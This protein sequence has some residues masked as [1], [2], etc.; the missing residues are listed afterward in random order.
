MGSCETCKH[1]NTYTCDDCEHH[2]TDLMDLYEPVEPEK[3]AEIEEKERQEKVTSAITEWLELDLTEEFKN[4]FYI[5]KKFSASNH[6]RGLFMAV[7]VDKDAKNLI[8]SDTIALIKMPCFTIPKELAGKVIFK[9]EGNRIGVAEKSLPA[10]Q[11]EFDKFSE[12]DL[13][14]ID[15]FVFGKVEQIEGIFGKVEQIEGIEFCK[16]YI[17]HDHTK[18]IFNSHYLS[19]IQDVLGINVSIAYTDKNSA[20]LF[21]DGEIEVICLPLRQSS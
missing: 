5:V 18:I 13:I 17:L 21:T 12:I 1:F 7:W 9:L 4:A 20:V 15:E 2:Y 11:I 19:L 6:F 3:M 16:Q 8:A 14:A 10:Y